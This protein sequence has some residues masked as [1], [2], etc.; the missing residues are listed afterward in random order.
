MEYWQSKT[1]HAGQ[2]WKRNK[3]NNQKKNTFKSRG[4]V[5][6]PYIKGVSEAFTRILKEHR[7]CT[8]VKNSKTTHYIEE[9]AG[10]AQDRIVDEEKARWYREYPV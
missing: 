1:A 10:T 3:E 8:T 9:P 7:I 5:T 4:M 6:V 2:E